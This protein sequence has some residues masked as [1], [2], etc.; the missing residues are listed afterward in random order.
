[1]PYAVS[2]HT[3]KYLNQYVRDMYYAYL[4]IIPSPYKANTAKATAAK[5]PPMEAALAIAPLDEWT[6]EVDEL[7]PDVDEGVLEA[8]AVA[9][10]P[11]DP[12]ELL[13]P[14]PVGEANPDDAVPEAAEPEPEEPD[15]PPDPDGP[16]PEPE[17]PE[18][19]EPD[20]PDDPDPELDEEPEEEDPELDEDA[21]DADP[22][23][24]PVAVLEAE[25]EEDVALVVL[26]QLRS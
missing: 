4:S 21:E 7:E 26:E 6:V 19:E 14:A 9:R 5:R 1:M 10:V 22:E 8:A 12:E 2:F 17:E 16:D 24:V 18:P 13:P 20:D 3:R 11:L 15:D 23:E 25:E